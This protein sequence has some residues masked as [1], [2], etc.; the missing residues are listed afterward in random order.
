MDEREGK[1]YTVWQLTR[2]KSLG[3]G[4]EGIKNNFLNVIVDGVWNR[5]HF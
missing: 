2:F 1:I 4:E 5:I 3:R